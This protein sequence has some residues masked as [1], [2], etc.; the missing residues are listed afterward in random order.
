MRK[1]DFE[2]ILNESEGERAAA[3]FLAKNAEILRWSVCRTGGHSNYVLKEFPF[4][5]RYKA[6]FVVLTAYS[7]VWDIHFI[8]LEPP[9]DR[10][11]TKAGL[12]SQRLN[13]AISQINDWRE[14]I[15]NNKLALQKDL[16]KWCMT[17]D[18]LGIENPK[19]IPNNFSN[20]RLNS[21][22]TVIRCYYYIFIGNRENMN[23]ETRRRMNQVSNFHIDVKTYGRFLDIAENLDTYEKEPLK[24]IRITKSDE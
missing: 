16:T 15:D 1:E 13:K 10:V 22:D 7:G 18:L 14:Y 11:I 17:K 6:D 4:G 23:E 5:S 24:S 19:N 8:E 20:N 9:K 3:E 21:I 2:K 12:P